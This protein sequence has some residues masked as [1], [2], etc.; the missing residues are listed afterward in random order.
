MILILCAQCNELLAVVIATD[1]DTDVWKCYLDDYMNY[2]LSLQKV[3]SIEEH[4]P[5][6][7]VGNEVLQK[8]LDQFSFEKPRRLIIFHCYARVF[9]IKIAQMATAL[10]PLQLSKEVC[11]FYVV[12]IFVNL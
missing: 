7:R 1:E 3:P 4:A 8:Y 12:A 5:F 9:N 6:E 2:K 10:C 11:A